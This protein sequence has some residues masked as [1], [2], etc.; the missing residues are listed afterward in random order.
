MNTLYAEYIHVVAD[1]IVFLCMLIVYII[2]ALMC[3]AMVHIVP[4]E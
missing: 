1:T 3:I 2:Q 4:V